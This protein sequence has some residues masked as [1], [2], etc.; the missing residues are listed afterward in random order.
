MKSY[1]LK[2]VIAVI[3]LINLIIGN[4]FYCYACSFSLALPGDKELLDSIAE[5][6]LNNEKIDKKIIRTMINT[7]L[8]YKKGEEAPF[9]RAALIYLG[10]RAPRRYRQA[11]GK[12]YRPAPGSRS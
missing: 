12:R 5:Q 4:I 6:G 10:Y 3:V 11:L 9:E 1:T 7:C 2:K 8:G